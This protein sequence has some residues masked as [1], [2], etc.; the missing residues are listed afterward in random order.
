ML[1]S[2]ILNHIPVKRF[3]LRPK[4]IYMALMIRRIILAMKDASTIDDKVRLL[5][6]SYCSCIFLLLFRRICL[7]SS[8]NS[9]FVLIILIILFCL[10]AQDYYG[11]KRL[12][13]AGQLLALLFE[14]LLKRLNAE[15]KRGAK[16]VLSKPNKAA[17][18]DI[19]QEIHSNAHLITNGLTNAIATGNWSLKRFK[20]DRQGV[21][22]PLSRLSYISALGMMT[23]I[24]SQFEKTRKVSGP[25]S[26]QPSQW[27][28]ICPSDTPEGESCG[29]VK[30]LALMTHITT[31]EDERPLVRLAFNL[32]VQD[33]ALLSG[34]DISLSDAFLVFLNGAIM[35]IHRLP[36]KFVRDFRALRRAGRIKEFVS[37]YTHSAQRALYIASDAGRV[38]RPLIIVERGQP[39]V[40]AQHIKEVS[41]G[42][43]Q[44]DSLVRDGLVEYL[45][46]NEENNSLIGKHA[47][48]ENT[49]NS[50]IVIM[51]MSEQVC[52]ILHSFVML[53]TYLHSAVRERMHRADHARGDRAADH[54]G[55]VRWPD[56][57][58]APQPIAAQ[59]LPVR[60]GQ[61]GHGRHR[62]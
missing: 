38:C 21:T 50:T 8:S 16:D 35:G 30:N 1:N 24:T 36:E 13:L 51:I 22:Q 3:D 6:P 31:D 27:G 61:A 57:V 9:F 5:V 52:V 17:P 60:H 43:R 33:T 40:T 19:L 55:R 4:V 45:D 25:R 10:L 44:F 41:E 46:V 54:S 49:R 14:D 56:P 42:R 58:P 62:L 28:M 37:V 2:V 7:F 23:R 12:E 11:N 18:F 48:N 34:D 26:L 59:H 15:L 47:I 29:L 53:I 39:R 32:G 20:M